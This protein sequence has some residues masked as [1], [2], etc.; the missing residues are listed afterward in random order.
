LYQNQGGE[1]EDEETELAGGPPGPQ[2]GG[3]GSGYGVVGGIDL[4]SVET[5]SVVFQTLFGGRNP[6]GIEFAAVDEGF[7]GP[8]A[9]TDMDVSSKCYFTVIAILVVSL[10]L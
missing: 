1:L 5:G 3:M 6:L 8:G 9:G 7:F 10:A 4:D 2:L